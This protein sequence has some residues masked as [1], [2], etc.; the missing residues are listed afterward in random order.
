[1]FPIMCH[2]LSLPMLVQLFLLLLLQRKHTREMIWDAVDGDVSR[3]P[4]RSHSYHRPKSREPPSKLTEWKWRN[5]VVVVQQQQYFRG[6]NG[7]R[8]AGL[9]FLTNDEKTRDPADASGLGRRVAASS[10]FTSVNLI[11]KTLTFR[12]RR[13]SCC[14][15]KY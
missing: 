5:I 15:R 3:S 10:C 12:S 7:R 13:V 8:D 1:M 4:R 11:A 2:F 14:T 6:N 9:V